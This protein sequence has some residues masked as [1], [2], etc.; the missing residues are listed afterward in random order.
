VNLRR[1]LDQAQAAGKV[2]F[3]LLGLDGGPLAGREDL[4]LIAPGGLGQDHHDRTGSTGT[5]LPPLPGGGAI[6]H[7]LARVRAALMLA[8]CRQVPR[9]VLDQQARRFANPCTDP[10]DFHLGTGYSSSQGYNRVS[11]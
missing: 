3:A 4:E 7:R 6:R 9:H 5:D 11:G 8:F 2:T 1:A 10:A